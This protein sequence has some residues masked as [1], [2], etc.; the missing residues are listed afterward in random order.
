MNSKF[1]TPLG[2]NVTKEY[3][4]EEGEAKSKR[5]SKKKKNARQV[6]SSSDNSEEEKGA[7]SE[8]LMDF[9]KLY[10]DN[11]LVNDPLHKHPEKLGNMKKLLKLQACY[12]HHIYQMKE[13][14][15]REFIKRPVPKELGTLMLTIIRN[16]SGFN[17]WYPKYT[18]IGYVKDDEDKTYE[19][20]I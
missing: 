10:P 11:L 3:V 14:E 15:C 8:S 18:L 20:G 2:D 16:K 5:K 6:Q 12:V 17:R 7:H 19:R 4:D 1:F 13:L 9:V